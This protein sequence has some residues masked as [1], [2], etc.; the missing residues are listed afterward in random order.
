MEVNC[1]SKFAMRGQWDNIV[2]AYENNPM[3]REVKLTRSGDTALQIAAAAGQT[4]I[5]SE[6]VEIHG[7]KMHQTF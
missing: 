5:V 2:Q 4:N 1:L 6:L 7:K 3:S